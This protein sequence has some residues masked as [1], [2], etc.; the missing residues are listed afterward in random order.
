[1]EVERENGVKISEGA[2]GI[3]FRRDSSV[4]DTVGTDPEE[5]PNR[6]S[7]RTEKSPKREHQWSG[8]VGGVCEVPRDHWIIGKLHET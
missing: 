3:E 4:V 5:V 2:K 6:R 7:F 8:F 1:L